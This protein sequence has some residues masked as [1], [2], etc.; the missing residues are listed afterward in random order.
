ME[1]LTAERCRH[2]L[3]TALVGHLGVVDNNGIYVTPVS[4]VT[5]GSSI[6]V[7]TAPGRRLDAIRSSPRVCVETCSFDAETGAWESVIVWGDAREVHS[8]ATLQHVV[9]DLLTKYRDSIGNLLSPTRD[10]AVPIDWYVVV[11][12]PIEEMTGRG[13]EGSFHL[14]TRPGR[15]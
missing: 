2:V 4:Y 1:A 9:G 10:S 11:E 8:A 6:F 14:P 3:E 15:L 13:S 5:R 7:R 12:I